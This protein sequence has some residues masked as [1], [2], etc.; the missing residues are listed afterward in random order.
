MPVYFM[1]SIHGGPV[2]IGYSA[3]VR[4]RRQRLQRTYKCKLRI[5]A[6]MEGGVR[7]EREIHQRFAHLRIGTTEQFRSGRD[8]MEYLGLPP[9]VDDED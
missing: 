3:N 6:T 8:L 2:K 4:E 5:L 7:E 9:V 1:R